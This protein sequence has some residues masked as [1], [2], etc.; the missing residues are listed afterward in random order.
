MK[1][2]YDVAL[3]FAGEDREYV[4]KVAETLSQK[5]VSVF[6]DSFEQEQLWG[7]D[8]Y[9][10][11]SNIYKDKSRFTIIFISR[12]Y[13]R[14][15]WTQHELK[16]AQA[17]AF[18]EN[19][20][21]ILPARFD[22]TELPGIPETIG[23]INLNKLSPSKFADIILKKL[24]G[25][26]AE[27]EKETIKDEVQEGTV[28]LTSDDI[29]I[30]EKK[31]KQIPPILYSVNT[32][33]KFLI[34]ER[35]YNQIHYVWCAPYFDISRKVNPRSSN[36][37]RIYNELKEAVSSNDHHSA[38]I[39]QNKLGLLRDAKANLL[40]GVISEGSYEQIEEIVKNMSDINDFIPIVYVIP[41]KGIEDLI[42]EV[43]IKMKANPF[44]QEFIIEE[45]PRDKFDII[46]IDEEFFE[47][48]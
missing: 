21:Y 46:N 43:P 32:K 38:K 29:S 36:P 11:L 10:Y 18:V 15:Q 42:K 20:E 35:Y 30:G 9:Q 7:K 39:E 48:R 28:H 45:L 3:S 8:L 1:A 6:Y 37:I 14:K 41:T 12:N 22:D 23:Y 24:E 31:I 33:I 2:K 19:S 27:I 40:K 13:A 34:S 16:S 44:S 26:L 4:Q 5:G 25:S 17:R 47:S